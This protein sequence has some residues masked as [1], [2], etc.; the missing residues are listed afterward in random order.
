MAAECRLLEKTWNEFMILH[1]VHIFLF[2][3]SL[4]T[5]ESQAKDSIQ[6]SRSIIA[7]VRLLIRHDC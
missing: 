2:Q 7:H 6:I 3:C 1:V 5:S 4:S